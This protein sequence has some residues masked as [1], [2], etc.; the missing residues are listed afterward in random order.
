MKS[1]GTTKRKLGT[2]H[3]CND[4]EKQKGKAHTETEP[5]NPNFGDVIC[6]KVGPDNSAFW[7]HAKRKAINP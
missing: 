6:Q 5:S 2:Q 4:L 7:V 1:K 3:V